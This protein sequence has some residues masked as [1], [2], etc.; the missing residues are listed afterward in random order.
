M[1]RSDR[2]NIS[3]QDIASLLTVINKRWPSKGHKIAVAAFKQRRQTCSVRVGG[4]FKGGS[5]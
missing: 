1:Y 2:P 5:R 4:N 3:D